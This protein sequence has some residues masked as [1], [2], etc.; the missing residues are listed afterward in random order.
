[1]RIFFK[2]RCRLNPRQHQ[3]GYPSHHKGRDDKRDEVL[4]QLW[5]RSLDVCNLT[6][7]RNYP[8][9]AGIELCKVPLRH[10]RYAVVVPVDD[11]WFRLLPDLAYNIQIWV[12]DRDSGSS[13]ARFRLEGLR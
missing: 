2:D 1:M 13:S 7:R 5:K 8:V 9:E 4:S 3:S 11:Q 12:S 10:E 6:A